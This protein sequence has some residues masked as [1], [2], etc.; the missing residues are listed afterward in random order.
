LRRHLDDKI[1]T[2]LD[3]ADLDDDARAIDRL[4]ATSIASH[5]GMQDAISAG[6]VISA[7]TRSRAPR[8]ECF[9]QCA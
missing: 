3:R 4:P 9:R 5:P 1:E 7:K 2:H 8:H 6:F